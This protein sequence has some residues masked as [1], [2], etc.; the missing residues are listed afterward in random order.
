MECLHDLE[1]KGV[2]ASW[3]HLASDAG[4]VVEGVMLLVTW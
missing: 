1:S 2:T 3:I 4:S